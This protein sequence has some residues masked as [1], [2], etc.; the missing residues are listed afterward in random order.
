MT[1]DSRTMNSNSG[2]IAGGGAIYSLGV[3]GA[4]FW[5][6]DQADQFWEYIWAIFQGIF[7]PAF[8]VYQVFQ[9]LA[10]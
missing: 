5:F 10:S 4:W 7:W 8:M 9:S 3:I 1:D 2:C 6:W